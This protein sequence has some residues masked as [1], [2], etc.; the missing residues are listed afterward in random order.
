M[1]NKQALFRYENR[2]DE[3]FKELE[4]FLQSEA[5]TPQNEDQVIPLFKNKESGLTITNIAENLFEKGEEFNKVILY[6][7]SKLLFG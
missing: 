1:L 4:A 5:Y 2:E 7:S 6:N 3:E